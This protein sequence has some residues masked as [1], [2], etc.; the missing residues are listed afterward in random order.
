MFLG[1]LFSIHGALSPVLRA[2]GL[3]TLGISS[4][5]TTSI[6]KKFKIERAQLQKTVLLV[7][8]RILLRYTCKKKLDG[9]LFGML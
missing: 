7:R 6:G 9:Y 8:G 1:V 2:E 3:K 4:F 5:V